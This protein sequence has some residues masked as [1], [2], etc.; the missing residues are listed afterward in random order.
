[1]AEQ[2]ITENFPNSAFYEKEIL[3]S[4]SCISESCYQIWVVDVSKSESIN[5][6]LESENILTIK[7]NVIV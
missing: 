5:K 3:S 1:M 7:Q 2:L 6:Y 4:S